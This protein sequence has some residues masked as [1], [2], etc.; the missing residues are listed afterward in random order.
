MGILQA[1]CSVPG[2]DV[3]SSGEPCA[4]QWMAGGTGERCQ[5]EQGIRMVS[6]R[7]WTLFVSLNLPVV[8]VLLNKGLHWAYCSLFK[9]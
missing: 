1:R 7:W 2:N 8:S 4:M 5:R 6:F 9:Y 3:H